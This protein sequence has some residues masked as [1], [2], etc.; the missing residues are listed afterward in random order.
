MAGWCEG[1]ECR[2]APDWGHAMEEEEREEEGS[3]LQVVV[4][5]VFEVA[6][7]AMR[8]TE[9][10]P[11]PFTL[12]IYSVDVCHVIDPLYDMFMK[13]ADL[14]GFDFFAKALAGGKTTVQG[15]T[16]A[17]PR[18]KQPEEDSIR[19]CFSTYIQIMRICAC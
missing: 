6:Q 2:L 1:T 5:R 3:S 4:A 18:R 17:W 8:I 13:E 10:I 19:Y 14:F 9:S 11:V 12:T 7:K 16:C 15:V